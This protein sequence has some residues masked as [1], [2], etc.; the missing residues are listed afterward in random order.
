[1]QSQG[2]DRMYT[3]ITVIVNDE[4][5]CVIHIIHVCCK[6]NTILPIVTK[7]AY[8]LHHAVAIRMIIVLYIHSLSCHIIY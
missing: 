8:T 1:M 5:L 6:I 3:A 2:T 4:H 7:Q